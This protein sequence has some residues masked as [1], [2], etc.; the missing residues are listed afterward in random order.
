MSESQVAVNY[1]KGS[2]SILAY[3]IANTAESIKITKRIAGQHR[4]IASSAVV[5][6]A[7]ERGHLL[8]ALYRASRSQVIFSEVTLTVDIAK[9]LSGCS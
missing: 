2:S 4:S 5:D 7:I 6:H 8:F 3:L 9:Q 1:L